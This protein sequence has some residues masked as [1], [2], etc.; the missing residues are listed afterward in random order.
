[1]EIDK[2]VL[3]PKCD[4]S[5]AKSAKDVE[6]CNVCGGRG[7]RVIK[8]MLAPG[9]YQQMQTTYYIRMI[10]FEYLVAINVEAREKL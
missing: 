6:T 5:G 9:F 4:G 2:Q 3:C 7:I 10:S 8:Q 1:M